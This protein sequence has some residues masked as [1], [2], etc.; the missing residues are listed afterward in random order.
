MDKFPVAKIDLNSERLARVSPEIPYTQAPGSIA[1]ALGGV[2]IEFSRIERMPRYDE[3]SREND[4][5]H[6]FMLSLVATELAHR[7][8][9]DTLDIG[10]VAQFCPVH[11]LI[12]IETGDIPTFHHSQFDMEAKAKAEQA[13][14]ERLLLRLP[15]YTG[16]LLQQYEQQELPEARFVR[17][18]DKLLPVIVDILGKGRKVME[19]DYGVETYDQLTFS[20]IKLHDRIATTFAEFPEI[21][22]AHDALLQIFRIIFEAQLMATRQLESRTPVPQG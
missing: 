14:M 22:E 9:P 7:L 19:E 18:I 3:R 17:A 21:V 6:S 4:A 11:D 13:A 5:E 15:R 8:Y 16:W 20:H 2:A 1:L 12:E 10:L